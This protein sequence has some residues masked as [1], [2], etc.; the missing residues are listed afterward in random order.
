MDLAPSNLPNPARGRAATPIAFIRSILLAYRKYGADPANA[1]EKSGITDSMLADPQ[2]RVTATQLKII[3]IIAMQELDDEALGWFSRRLPWGSYG[4]LCRASLTSP[5]LEVAL[6]RW[7]RHHRLL[8]DDIEFNLE[9][10]P[11]EARLTISSHMTPGD[12]CEFCLVTNLRYILGYAC[13]LIDSQV[14]LLETRFPF[15]APLHHDVYPLIFPGPIRFES[16]SVGFSFD[17]LYLTLPTRRDERA[18]QVMLQDALPLT[19]FQY[20]KDR[21]LVHRVHQLLI[22]RVDSVV[23]AEG[24]AEHLHITV[25]TLHRQLKEEGVCLQ[26]LKNQTRRDRAIELLSRTNRTIKQVANLVGFSD[27]K[28]FTR[29]FNQWTGQAPGAFSRSLIRAK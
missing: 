27:E 24:I 21:L 11:D 19:I 16:K 7:C 12:M 14:P 18:L 10:T 6:K 8:T 4:M 29:A 5:N 25:R 2:A 28:S 17:P 9:S 15:P 22:D 20:R 1:L 13:W 26:Q 3:S 23:T